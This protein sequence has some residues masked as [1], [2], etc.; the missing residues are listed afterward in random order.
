MNIDSRILTHIPEGPGLQSLGRGRFV[1]SSTYS[2]QAGRGREL[3]CSS[4]E[5]SVD[6]LSNSF[7]RVELR[8]ISQKTPFVKG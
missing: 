5:A 6:Y 1:S 8:S 3:V 7:L 4:H 2:R